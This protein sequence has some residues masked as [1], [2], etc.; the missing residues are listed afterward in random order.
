MSP[1]SNL[2]TITMDNNLNNNIEGQLA[3]QLQ[4][5]VVE[6]NE[7]EDKLAKV[8]KAKERKKIQKQLDD[9]MAL[10]KSLTES[11]QDAPEETSDKTPEAAEEI[12]QADEAPKAPEATKEAPE[13]QTP[14]EA[15]KAPEATEAP[16]VKAP[17]A[18]ATEAPKTQTP[19]P[20]VTAKD[21]IPTMKLEDIA[22]DDKGKPTKLFSAIVYAVLTVVLGFVAWWYLYTDTSIVAG[23]AV[24]E[25]ATAQLKED[26]KPAWYRWHSWDVRVKGEAIVRWM[27]AYKAVFVDGGCTSTKGEATLYACGCVMRALTKKGLSIGEAAEQLDV[28]SFEQF[29]A[30][31][32]ADATLTAEEARAIKRALDR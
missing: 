25:R 14:Q 26:I 18:K 32:D 31:L 22:Q 17:K 2:K 1:T 6:I 4:K 23:A 29:K 11:A 28:M 8:S 12:P 20:K 9:K 21:T 3:D 7:L 19:A 15:P 10:Y 5:L 30:A 27:P 24:Y 16:K 13:E